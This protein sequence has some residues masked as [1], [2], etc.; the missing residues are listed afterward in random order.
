[1]RYISK[2]PIGG[3]HYP[4]IYPHFARHF[5]PR[6]GSLVVGARRG[7]W[8]PPAPGPTQP[9]SRAHRID[10]QFSLDPP[11]GPPGLAALD[12][13]FPCSTRGRRGRPGDLTQPLSC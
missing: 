6:R 5:G 1:L 7:S 2:L 3:A 4:H 12:H 10:C 9:A 8:A 11:P 13:P